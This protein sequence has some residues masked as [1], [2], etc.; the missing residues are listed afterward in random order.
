[1]KDTVL[2]L[3]DILSGDDLEDAKSSRKVIEYCELEGN[4]FVYE[5]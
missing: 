5:W 2:R 4:Y 3:A 1:M